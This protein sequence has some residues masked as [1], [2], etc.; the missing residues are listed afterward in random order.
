MRLIK[1][2]LAR[3]DRRRR[4]LF[5]GCHARVRGRAASAGRHAAGMGRPRRSTAADH[6]RHRDWDDDGHRRRGHP[7]RSA[8]PRRARRDR[9]HRQQRQA[10]AAAQQQQQR[11]PEPE[12]Y[13]EESAYQPPARDD[14]YRNGGMADA[15]DTCVAEV[16]AGRGAVSSVDRASRSGE[17]GTSP[18]SS[19]AARPTRAGSTARA[20]TDIEA[21]DFAASFETPADDR[22]SLAESPET[23]RRTRR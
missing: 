8:D 13:P 20:V 21:G 19:T 14:R 22:A 9:R 23:T 16:E 15:V 10:P 1:H 6:R 3:R 11:Y 4:G 17:G 12:P 18:A 2:K 5:S 7:H